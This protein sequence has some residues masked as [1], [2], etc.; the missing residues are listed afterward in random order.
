M[1]KI[2]ILKY[3]KYLKKMECIICFDDIINK[4]Y[5]ITSCGHI[6]HTSCL[7]NWSNRGNALCPM[8]RKQVFGE[9]DIT[10]FEAN[11]GAVQ[12]EYCYDVAIDNLN[13]EETLSQNVA[14]MKY[15]IQRTVIDMSE[16]Y[17]ENELIAKDRHVSYLKK[18]INDYEFIIDNA[19]VFIVVTAICGF[20]I[21]VN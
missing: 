2:E 10:A 14:M 17:K 20:I 13:N 4:D 11:V 21:S 3:L 16:L 19:L 7:M 12:L 15:A 9:K 5:S 8:C 6:F 1:K 18:K